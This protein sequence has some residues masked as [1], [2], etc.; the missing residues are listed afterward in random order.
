MSNIGVWEQ[1]EP[2]VQRKILKAGKDLMMMEVHFEKGAEGYEHS[3]VH[4]QMSYC[5]KGS[6]VFRIDGKEYAV[7]QGDSIV[8]P[9]EAKHGVT[10]LEEGSA[11]LDVFTPLREDLLKR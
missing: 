2:G 6:F 4:E 1:A 7:S 9:S 5:L 8:I 3:H 11:L 10:S